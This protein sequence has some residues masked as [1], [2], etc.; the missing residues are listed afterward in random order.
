MNHLIDQIKT[1]QLLYVFIFVYYPSCPHPPLCRHTHVFSLLLRYRTLR[2]SPPC[3]SLGLEFSTFSSLLRQVFPARPANRAPLVTIT[4]PCSFL[5]ATFLSIWNCY[6]FAYLYFAYVPP[7]HTTRMWAP[8]GQ[9]PAYLVHCV[10][11]ALR[12]WDVFNN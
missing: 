11:S 4:I 10:S 12:S 3:S 2:A 7:K 1:H 8:W 9:K 6:L 5:L